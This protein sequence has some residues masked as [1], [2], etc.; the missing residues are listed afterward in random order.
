LLNGLDTGAF[1]SC[2]ANKQ[3]GSG[4]GSGSGGSTYPG[5]SLTTQGSQGGQ[6]Q[7][8]G[9]Q[10]GSG[11]TQNEKFRILSDRGS[12]VVD[13]RT[14]T[15]IL[16]ETAK[17][18]EEAKKLIRRLDVPVR[19]VMIEVR[20]VVA[21]NTFARQLGVRFGVA[22]QGSA[23]GGKTFGIGGV[24]TQGN[25]TT[26]STTVTDTLVDLA[27]GGANPYGALGMTLARGADYVLNLELSA[28]QDQNRGELLS[29]PRVLTSDRCQATIKQGTQIP[30]RVQQGLGAFTVEFK[31]ATLTLDVLPQITPSGSIVMA[32]KVSKDAVGAVTT[33]GTGIDTRQ[34]ETNVH[35]MDGETVVLGGI[36]EGTMLDNNKKVPFF[37]DLPGVGFLFKN[38]NKR[39]DKQ[40][41]L[42]FVTPKIV[43]DNV[44]TN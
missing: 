13:A 38:T 32:L 10:G 43:K 7:G 20:I 24:G 2:G 8:Q 35:V 31:D 34:L 4:S 19:Q 14:N 6:G 44:A 22:K 40:E 36:F 17:R 33:E 27:A 5:S 18:L 1:G 30:Y 42:I 3:A 41:L 37:A 16:R 23:G 12:V 39:D 11:N 9:G 21:S 15:L 26:G 28:L 25:S 29:N